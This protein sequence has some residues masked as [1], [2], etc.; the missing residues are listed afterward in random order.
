MPA[1]GK[2]KKLYFDVALTFGSSSIIKLTAEDSTTP[3][4]RFG[5]LL[6]ARAALNGLATGKQKAANEI[7]AI[8]Q[9]ADSGAQGVAC[10]FGVDFVNTTGAPAPFYDNAGN[11]TGTH[12][13]ADLAGASAVFSAKPR[14]KIIARASSGSYFGTLYIQQQHSIEV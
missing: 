4:D 1:T 12:A 8:Y 5:N 10:L 9:P 13:V 3:G 6:A 7:T 14:V 11:H 2:A